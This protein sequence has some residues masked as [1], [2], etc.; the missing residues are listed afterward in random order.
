M[1]GL[2]LFL[3]MLGQ[4]APAPSLGPTGNEDFDYYYLEFTENFFK[5]DHKALDLIE[6]GLVQAMF[7]TTDAET[8]KE[9]IHL[10]HQAALQHPERFVLYDN[11]DFKLQKEFQIRLKAVQQKKI[12]YS[13]VGAVVGA[14]VAIPIG[15]HFVAKTGA[16][17]LWLSIPAAALAGAGAGYLLADLLYSPDYHYDEG[18]LTRDLDLYREEILGEE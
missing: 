14:V 4:T 6:D 11:L 15:K 1:I 3:G 5:T 13:V 8:F 18:S 7:S 9:Y 2:I 12:I 16:K 10:L 17:L